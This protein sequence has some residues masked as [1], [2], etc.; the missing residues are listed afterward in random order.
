MK[1]SINNFDDIATNYRDLHNENLKVTGLDSNYF[2]E[3]KI[4]LISKDFNKNEVLRIL[5][6]GCG[7]GKLEEYLSLYFKDSFIEG[8]DVSTES[9]KIAESKK[10]LNSNFKSYDGINIPYCDDTFDLVIIAQVLHHVDIPNHLPLLKEINRV[11]KLNGKI[12][13]FEHNPLNPFT[14]YI[15]KTCP[16]D[17][18]VSLLS[19]NYLKKLLGTCN[20]NI[21]F[22]YFISF[23]PNKGI[24]KKLIEFEYKLKKVILGGQYYIKAS[25]LK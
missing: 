8:I 18:G 12:Y 4:K 14:K 9:I 5:D 17:K 13:I 10:I 15:V 7:D 23:F 21:D 24:F 3:K 19:Y 22:L 2:A 1:N 20:F 16:F 11:L 25:K 6:L